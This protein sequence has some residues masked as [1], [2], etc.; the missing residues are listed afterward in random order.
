MPEKTLLDIYESR[1]DL[2][3]EFP[4]VTQKGKSGDW[5]INDWWNQYGQKEMP[6]TTLVQPTPKKTFIMPSQLE[7]ATPLKTTEALPDVNNYQAIIAGSIPPEKTA[8][9]LEQEKSEASIKQ[10]STDI[11]SLLGEQEGKGAYE[12]GLREEKGMSQQEKEIQDLTSQM[13]SLQMESQARQIATEG[14][15]QTTAHIAGAIN[16]EQR[17]TAIQTLMLSAQLQVKQNNYAL[18][19]SQIQRAISL[20]YQPI[21]DKIKVLQT[22]YNMN[23]DEL[24]RIDKKRADETASKIK[25]WEMQV[26]YAKEQETRAYNEKIQTSKDNNA[27]ALEAAKGGAPESVINAIKDA[28]TTL[29]AIGYATGFLDTDLQLSLAKLAQDN[30]SDPYSLGGDIVQKNLATGEIRTAVNIPRGGKS[31]QTEKDVSAYNQ[32]VSELTG[33]MGSD[34]YVNTAK[35]SELKNKYPD[36]F[37]KYI[38]P[39]EWLN[40]NDPTARKFFLTSSQAIKKEEEEMTLDSILNQL[41]NQG[42]T[43]EETKRYISERYEIEEKQLDTA[44]DKYWEPVNFWSSVNRNISGVGKFTGTPFKSGAEWLINSLFK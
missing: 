29:D 32:I 27:I 43:R 41:K 10:T 23:R 9:Q 8:T 15:T 3:T 35:Y 2:K 18:A 13:R 31:T 21:E 14:G 26:D 44:L 7:S 4:D 33:T 11:M 28:E 24:E 38:V 36:V 1:P 5:T 12:A 17:K 39:E 6:D 42:N 20:K 30:W 40:P 19:E 25:Q 34:G 16:Q 22:Q 37:K